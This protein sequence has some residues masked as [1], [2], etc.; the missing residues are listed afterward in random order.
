MSLT[1]EGLS[2][3]VLPLPDEQSSRRLGRT[4]GPMLTTI[5]ALQ[6]RNEKLR[7]N[8][9]LLLPRLLSGRIDVFRQDEEGAA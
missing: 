8:R 1:N 9:D 3:I 7:A 6:L 4:V 5:A 2:R